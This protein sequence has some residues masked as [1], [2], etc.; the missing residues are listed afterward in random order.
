MM[1]S[2]ACGSRTY[3]NVDA[4]YQQYMEA[5][6]NSVKETA[7]GADLRVQRQAILSVGSKCAY[8]V[9]ADI[10]AWP[11]WDSQIK[12][13]YF[14][15]GDAASEGNVFFQHIKDF[16]FHARILVAKP[17]FRLRWRGQSPEGSGPIGIHTWTFIP[18]DNGQTL[19]INDEHFHA[20]Y[21]RP[22]GWFTDLGIA[23]QFDQ[24]IRDL[25][26]EAKKRCT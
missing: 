24:S 13:T 12:K 17:G 6:T 4:E 9:L 11:N 16:Q 19:V 23:K 10:K 1:M 3:S 5:T 14:V 22:L 20:W 2:A 18:L 26:L 15:E 7:S 8:D 21:V 25:E